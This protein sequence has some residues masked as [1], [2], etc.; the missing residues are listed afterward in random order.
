[1]SN[2]NQKPLSI[3]EKI[4]QLLFIGIPGVSVDSET[5]RLLDLIK[6]GGVCLFARNIKEPKQTREL[7]DQIR[8][9]L[10]IEPFLSIDQEGGLVDRLRRV[11]APMPAA[12]K[13]PDLN[14]AGTQ[15]KIIAEALTQLGF[16][17]D[18]APV[19]DVI[20]ERRAKFQ[21]GLHSRAYGQSAVEVVE[22]AGEFLSTLQR[23]GI[24]G[25]LKHFPGLG[26]SEVDSHEELPTVPISLGDFESTDLY[27]YGKL[28]ATGEVHAVMVA[29]AAYPALALQETDQDG[30]LLPSSLSSNIVTKL[31]RQEIGFDGLVL[32]DDMEMGAIVKNYGI[33]EASVM[34]FLAGHDMV[35]I[36]A[37]VDAICE[38]HESIGLAVDSGRISRERLDSSLQRIAGLK[39]RL[40]KPVELHSDRIASITEEIS[41]FSQ[42]LA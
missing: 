42:S 40:E 27:P 19:V 16:N 41:R 6:P 20:D 18:F 30:K 25:C 17:M 31:L 37:S 14:A 38:S 7:N 24:I 12:S 28:I 5:E 36:C 13:V 21:N 35:S 23:N 3:G 34:A 39:A 1:M 33:G 4:G 8:S 22:I 10:A 26:A 9:S 29:H 32:T 15:A 2:D 11:L